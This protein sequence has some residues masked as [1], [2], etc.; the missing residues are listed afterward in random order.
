MQLTLK[1]DLPMDLLTRTGAVIDLDRLTVEFS[2]Q[3]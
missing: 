1:D 3:A 2:R